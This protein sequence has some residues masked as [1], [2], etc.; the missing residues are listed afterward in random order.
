MTRRKLPVTLTREEQDRLLETLHDRSPGRLRALCIVRLMLN[1]GLRGCEVRNLKTTDVDW[2]SGRILVNG[3]G[4]R[5]RTLWL[6]PEDLDLLRRWREV[7]DGLP[8]ANGFLFSGLD[9]RPLGERNLRKIVKGAI[10][11]AGLAKDP[12][13]H[14]LRHTFATDLLRQTKNL[15]LVQ[16]ALGHSSVATTEIYTHVVDEELEAALKNLRKGEIK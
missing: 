11:R 14:A 4:K 5:Q 8:Q 15:R 9:G 13:P 3:K 16:K 2:E 10:R 12:H 1:A 7:R 6:A